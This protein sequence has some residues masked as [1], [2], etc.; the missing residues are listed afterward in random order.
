MIYNQSNTI[1]LTPTHQMQNESFNMEVTPT[2]INLSYTA[3]NAVDR[4][5]TPPPSES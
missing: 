2:H 5:P 4:L 1:P 3:D